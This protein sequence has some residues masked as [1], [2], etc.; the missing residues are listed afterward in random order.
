MGNKSFHD[1]GT[2]AICANITNLTRISATSV[3]VEWE[4]PLSSQ[5]FDIHI[6][7]YE[8]STVIQQISEFIRRDG[9]RYAC[10]VNN[11]GNAQLLCFIVSVGSDKNDMLGERSSG[12]V[13][14]EEMCSKECLPSTPGQ[15]KCPILIFLFHSKCM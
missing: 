7:D 15:S 12:D 10:L 8:N 6:S 11:T 9:D 2:E 14:A 1:L 5:E 4:Y 13:T 3:V